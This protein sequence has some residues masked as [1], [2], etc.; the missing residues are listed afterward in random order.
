MNKVMHRGWWVEVQDVERRKLR[1]RRAR[2]SIRP[3]LCPKGTNHGAAAIYFASTSFYVD[4]AHIIKYP[5][6]SSFCK[7]QEIRFIHTFRGYFRSAKG[8]SKKGEMSDC[9][10]TGRAR[11]PDRPSK[12]QQY[13]TMPLPVTISLAPEENNS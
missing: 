9:V 6:G 4:N 10:Y 3:E 13:A 1:L 11:R 12:R 5:T 2:K 8:K 7:S